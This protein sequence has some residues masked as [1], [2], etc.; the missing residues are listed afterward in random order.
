MRLNKTQKE[1]I[2]NAI[3]HGGRF[4]VNRTHGRGSH[5]GRIDHG[6]RQRNAMFALEK[7]GLIRIVDTQTDTDFNRGYSVTCT[8]WAF[9]LTT[10]QK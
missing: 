10:N 9:V 5:G 1:L 6:S 8:S 4:F 2:D 7:L 3:L